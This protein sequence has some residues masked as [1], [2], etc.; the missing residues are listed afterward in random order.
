MSKVSLVAKIEAKEGKGDDLVAAFG[1]LLDH[2]SAESGTIH[3]VVHR[4]TTEPDVFYVTE[5]YENQAALDAHMGSEKFAAFG[6]SL[7]DIVASGDLQML[8][9][10]GAAKGLDL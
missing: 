4:S 6:G 8:V 5:I 2:V 3:Y 7:G 9:P 10:V 1:E